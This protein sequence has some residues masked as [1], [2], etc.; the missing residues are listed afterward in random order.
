MFSEFEFI[1]SMKSKYGL[2]RL[3]DDCAVLPKDDRTDTLITADMLVENVDFR[4]DWAAP[5]QIG[6]KAL[7]VSLSDIAAMG[8]DPKWAML[9]IGV[10]E[11]LWKTDFLERLYN[12]W[13]ALAVQ[14]GV[15]LIGGDVSKTSDH[16]VID[17]IVGG[18]VNQGQA[19][20]RSGAKQ[21][22][23]IYVSGKLGGA[24]AGLKLLEEGR[25][26][27][28]LSKKQL[29]PY[30]QVLLGKQ[31]M[32][33]G[34]VT[35]MID[36]SDGL[37]SDLVHICRASNVGAILNSSVIPLDP[38]IERYFPESEAIEMALNGGEDFQ[39][40]F[41]ASE[42][43][44]VDGITLIGEIIEDASE[45]FLR[46]DGKQRKLVPRGFQHF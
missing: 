17:S 14:F 26:D 5:E 2:S 21:G 28:E 3:G 22:D 27:P 32:S 43:V 44:D 23:L 33:W 34:L 20:L 35:S 18:E 15:E 9:S 11:K 37:S 38:E 25:S 19:V 10:S 7:A 12:G 4:L 42:T 30:P 40:L 29:K 36:V 16:L 1:N 46:E 13:H 45:I 39:L 6:H 8:G 24:A 31:L 41:T